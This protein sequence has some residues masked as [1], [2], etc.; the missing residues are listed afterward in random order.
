ML[1][2]YLFTEET[3]DL[4]NLYLYHP[5]YVI[6]E[7][8]PI[9]GRVLILTDYLTYARRMLGR[10]LRRP[11]IEAEMRRIA[12]VLWILDLSVE[13]ESNYVFSMQLGDVTF[14]VWLSYR[15]GR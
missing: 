11:H 9:S 3:I 2:I 14:C 7:R 6:I 12:L 8:H 1:L 10:L 5:L 13:G 15:F 4:Y